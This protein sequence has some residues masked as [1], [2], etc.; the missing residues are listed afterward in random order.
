MDAW[1]WVPVALTAW[2]GVAVAVGLWLGPVLKRWSQA[3]EA[4]EP[5]SHMPAGRTERVRYGQ[6]AA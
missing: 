6:W 4:P 5:H 3:R 2:F 1:W